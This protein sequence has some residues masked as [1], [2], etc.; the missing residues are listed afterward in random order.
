ME[1]ASED[2]KI[3]SGVRKED[4]VAFKSDVVCFNKIITD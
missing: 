4:N 2:T 1:M 3:K